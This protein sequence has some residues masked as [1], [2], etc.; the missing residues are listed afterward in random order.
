MRRQAAVPYAWSGIRR[1][2]MLVDAF[3]Q[4][5][6]PFPQQ[7]RKSALACSGSAASTSCDS[8]VLR[9]LEMVAWSLTARRGSSAFVAI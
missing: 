7:L 1:A 9:A 4:A 5:A 6:D 3:V 8:V 2:G